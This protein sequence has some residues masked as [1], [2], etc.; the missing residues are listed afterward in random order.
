MRQILESYS[1]R[2]L[3]KMISNT[4]IKNY[5][6]LNKEQTIKLMMRPENRSRFES[7]KMKS[8]RMPKTDISKVTREF[9]RKA[10]RPRELFEFKEASKEIGKKLKKN[11]GETIRVSRPIRVRRKKKN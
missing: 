11:V 5:A 4:N 6:K 10:K 2:E 3:R 9:K 7:I 8:E 1:L